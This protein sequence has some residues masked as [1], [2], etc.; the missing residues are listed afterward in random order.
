MKHVRPCLPVLAA[1]CGQG[2]QA[3]HVAGG[4]RRRRCRVRR[5]I[6]R[7]AAGCQAGDVIE[8]PPGKH[9]FDRSLSLRVDG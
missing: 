5:E 4:G 9:S 8:V 7:A 6:P 3:R 1:G 2:E